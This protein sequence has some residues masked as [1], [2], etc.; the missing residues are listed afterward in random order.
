L[1]IDWTFFDTTLPSGERMRYQVLRIAVPRKGRALPFLQLAYDLDDLSPNK[2]Q[3]QIEQDALLAVVAALP[4]SVRAVILADRGFGWAS[5]IAWL[6][7]H[8]LPRGRGRGGV[9]PR[10]SR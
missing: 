8:R 10:S 1:A 5:F 6:E 4:R 9:R 2:S 3:N 7:R